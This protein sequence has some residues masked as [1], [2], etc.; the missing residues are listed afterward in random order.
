M[1][2]NNKKYTTHNVKEL[3]FL[4][5]T[6]K[7]MSQELSGTLKVSSATICVILILCFLVHH[8]NV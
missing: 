8:V 4:D 2:V 1:H 3:T 7:V 5:D 6:I